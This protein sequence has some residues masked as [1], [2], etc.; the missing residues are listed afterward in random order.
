MK[1][2]AILT[3]CA[4]IGLSL[5]A[6]AAPAQ[7]YPTKPV[8]I[9][10]PFA[11]GSGPDSVLRVVGEKLTRAWGQQ[12]IVEN[13]P[14][15]N[16]FIAIEAAK[17]AAPDGYT[18]VQM[19]DTHLALQP[20]L[21]KNIPYDVNKDFDPVGTLFRVYFFV[22]VPANSNWKTMKDLVDAAKAK[23]G[24]VT[25]GSWFIGSPG[26]LGG[27]M[28]E[29]ATGTQMNHIPF[30]ETSQLYVAVGNNDVNW[31]FGSAASAGAMY[32]AGK[33]KFMAV[34]A[35]QRV[36]GYPDVPTVAEMGGPA[37]LEVK[38]WVA[39]FAPRGT[40]APIIEKINQDLRKALSEP[41]V[42]ERF[43]TFGFEPYASA[44]GDIKKEMEADS[45]RYG[46]I[47]KRAKISID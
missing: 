19:D 45:R 38:A 14:G 28:L 32:R 10:T 39:L 44:P 26:H 13:R 47:V 22:V 29:A 23:P 11:A 33:V 8:K 34:A 4:A 36:A 5:F 7:Q 35:P 24:E 25:Y 9:I 27:A 41:D 18:L 40:P 17:K 43:T 1:R 46:D 16:G 6:E 2:S 12:V 31:A 37:D 3:I 21:Y 30:K 20:H 15:G 42:R